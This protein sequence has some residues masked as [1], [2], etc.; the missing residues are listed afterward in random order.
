MAWSL[1]LVPVDHDQAGDHP[2]HCGLVRHQT[3]FD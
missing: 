2:S 3:L 1:V